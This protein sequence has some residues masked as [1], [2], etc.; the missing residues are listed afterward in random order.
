MKSPVTIKDIAKLANVA[1]STV[2]KALNNRPGISARTREHIVNIAKA[3]NFVPDAAG[4]ALKNRFTN[5]IGVVFCREDYPLRNPFF[6]RILEG[7]ESEIAFNHYNLVLQLI[8]NH[9]ETTIP[10]MIRER[11]VDGIVL[12]GVRNKAFIERLQQ[13]G[14]PFILIDPRDYFPQCPQVVIDNENGTFL[15]TDYL[16]RN[17]HRQIGFISGDLTIPSFTER[18]NGYKKAL[19]FHHIPFSKRLVKTGGFEAG[20]QQAQQLLKLSKRPSAVVAAYDI[21]ALHAYR[22]I[23]DAGLRIPEDISVVGFDDIDLAKM[24]IPA[25]TTV[26]VYKEQ[27]GSVAVR[28]LRTIIHTENSAAFTPIIPV[29]L[30]ERDSVKKI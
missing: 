1:Q 12:I 15:A 18:F 27:M 16:L 5:N 7:I 10:K 24:A 30:I 3:H 17:G 4:K 8:P 28:Q 21:S 2:S 19:A 22:A 23:N 11:Q 6:S 26:R 20:Y 13:A 29:K 25:L 9:E 14:T